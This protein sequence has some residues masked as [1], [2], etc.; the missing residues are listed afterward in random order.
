MGGRRKQERSKQREMHDDDDVYIC[1][2]ERDLGII[3]M[4]QQRL[5]F[6]PLKQFRDAAVGS[7]KQG[8]QTWKLTAVSHFINNNNNNNNNNNPP[9]LI[10]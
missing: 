3:L 5:F 10:I 8:S 1:R 9:N 6:L 2:G 4:N 7:D